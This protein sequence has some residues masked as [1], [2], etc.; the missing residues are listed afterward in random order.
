[1]RIIMNENNMSEIVF[2][3]HSTDRR[4]SFQ[5]E[6]QIFRSIEHFDGAMV[7]N[8]RRSVDSQNSTSFYVV[9]FTEKAHE[10]PYRLINFDKIVS[11][12]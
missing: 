5:E 9:M 12:E 4:E 2:K 6:Q 7:V 1:M 10:S 3:F 11:W 8:D